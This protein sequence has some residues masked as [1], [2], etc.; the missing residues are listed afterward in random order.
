MASLEL[1]SSQAQFFKS[2]KMRFQH[3][4]RD[5]FCCFPNTIR[6]KLSED[7]SYQLQLN[8]N[9][10]QLWRLNA[11]EPQ[12]VGELTTLEPHLLVDLLQSQQ[13]K[14]AKIDLILP[15]QQVLIRKQ[16][17]PLAIKDTLQQALTFELD[18][19][20]PFQAEEVWFDYRILEHQ[21]SLQKIL[22]EIAVVPKKGLQPLIEHLQ[23]AGFQ[24]HSIRSQ[25]AWETLNLL[26]KSYR[27]KINFRSILT[28]GFLTILIIILLLAGLLMPLWNKRVATI[29]TIH[30]LDEVKAQSEEVLKIREQLELNQKEAHFV[31][32]LRKSY[33]PSIQILNELTRLLP[34][35]TWLR[36][37]K[38]KDNKLDI[39]G[40]SNQAST[41]IGLLE[42]SPYFKNVSFISPVV[43]TRKVER[44]SIRLQVVNPTSNTVENE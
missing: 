32:N 16:Q 40:E 24:I 35:D 1:S 18:R 14:T 23:Q 28:S 17:F 44:F 8:Q 43:Q 5:L 29:A 6:K 9:Q 3:W 31:A 42:S 10:V 7:D 41:L 22:V 13:T 26:P 33:I 25:G 15:Q 34:N 2:I 11:D 4:K 39:K 12:I 20:T 30:K 36:Y 37:L 21:E 38:L 27:P 19:I